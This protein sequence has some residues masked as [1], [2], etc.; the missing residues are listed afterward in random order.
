MRSKGR[1]KD[2]DF[3]VSAGEKT[4]HTKDWSEAVLLA[5]AFSASRGGEEAVVD[6]VVHSK[7]G[8]KH[9]L[10]DDGVEQYEED[11]EASVFQ[12]VSIRAV[13]KGRI[14]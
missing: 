1:H 7:A 5:V 9:W 2:V 8:A 12:R 14:A 3:E 10:G 11:P 4:Q 13:D 6:V